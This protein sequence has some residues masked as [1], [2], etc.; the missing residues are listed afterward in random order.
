MGRGD[1]R[2]L[3]TAGAAQGCLLERP[4]RSRVGACPQLSGGRASNMHF[5]CAGQ[6]TVPRV[7]HQD[8]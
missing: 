2:G 7:K 5:G 8:G 1:H 4:V 3:Q 6:G